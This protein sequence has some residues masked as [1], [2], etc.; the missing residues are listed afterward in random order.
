MVQ[1]RC[2]PSEQAAAGAGGGAAAPPALPGPGEPEDA[3]EWFG[4][5]LDEAL[6]RVDLAVDA[7]R[8][9]LH[10]RNLKSGPGGGASA[11]A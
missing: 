2:V 11:R 1:T 5:L 3:V 10:V 9:A 4:E 8:A 7:A 6:L